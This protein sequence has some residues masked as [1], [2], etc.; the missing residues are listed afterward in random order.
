[1]KTGFLLIIAFT[2]QI[3]SAQEN[4]PI[5]VYTNNEA[6]ENCFQNIQL[7][8]ETI[9]LTDI[10][11][12]FANL[13]D[14]N[15]L[16]L[17]A[18]ENRIVLIGETHYSR[19]IRSL[20]NKLI[21]ALNT[22]DYYPLVIF[23]QPYSLTPFINHYIHI[24]DN[25]EAYNFFNTELKD[26]VL[27]VEDSITFEHLRSWNKIN[28]QKPI[29]IGFTDLEFN[30]ATTI[31]NILK[32]YFYS[33]KKISQSEID[34]ILELGKVQSNQFFFEVQR[35]LTLAKE[36]NTVGKYSFITISYITNVINNL[37]DT[38]NALRY[39]FNYFRQKSIVRKL[40]EDQSFGM[41]IN[42]K[43]AI[44]NGGANHMQ[45]KLAVNADFFPEGYFLNTISESTKNRVYSIMLDGLAF[46]LTGMADVDLNNCLR[47]GK[48][49]RSIVERMQK[50]YR[51]KIIEE[52]KNYFV[53][54]DRNDFEKMIFH[55]AYKQQNQ[56]I[57]F[58]NK[59]WDKI[60]LDSE[61]ENATSRKLK[62]EN[63][64]R[65]AYNKV[66]YIPYSPIVQAREKKN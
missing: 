35:L 25:K 50:A 34:K 40:T 15:W 36:Q 47:Q 29:D 41:Y 52:N 45:S 20:T 33:L 58:T 14:L 19:Y 6:G 13:N 63:D 61:T 9:A 8:P 39:D 11:T 7:Y 5:A 43:K 64:T 18:K 31:D 17:P 46:S 49:Y 55:Y 3:L 24:S 65:A 38:S 4:K 51:D 12:E 10:D 23:E 22:Y 62:I 16:K 60:N 28:L 57:G 53:F 66:F 44:L 54:G 1:M 56:A 2:F 32:P 21:F 59:D 30:Y 27:T 26:C 48:Q 42:D 37:L